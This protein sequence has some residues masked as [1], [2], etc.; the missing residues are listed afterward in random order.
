M[1]TRPWGIAMTELTTCLGEN[2]GRTLELCLRKVTEGSELGK[3][4]GKLG[5]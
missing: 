2:P 4:L 1:G 5:G 3:L